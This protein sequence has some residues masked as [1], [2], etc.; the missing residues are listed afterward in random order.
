MT[1][2]LPAGLSGKITDPVTAKR[3]LLYMA[4]EPEVRLYSGQGSV[5]WGGFSWMS[6]PFEVRGPRFTST[7][8]GSAEITFSNLDRTLSGLFLGSQGVEG[9]PATIYY[10]DRGDAVELLDGYLDSA[11]ISRRAVVKMITEDMTSRSAPRL[12]AGP[13]LANWITPSG[14]K[15][16]WGTERIEVNRRAR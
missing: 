6:F 15:I 2:P 10:Y 11:D 13:P 12:I 1:R 5:S 7:G 8:G 9:V 4:Y 14:T 16:S 3:W